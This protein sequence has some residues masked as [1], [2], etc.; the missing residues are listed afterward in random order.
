MGECNPKKVIIAG[1]RTFDDKQFL[2]DKVGWW[3]GMLKSVPTILVFSGTAAGA[4]TLGEA[5]AKYMGFHIVRWPPDWDSHG[6]KAGPVRNCQMAKNADVLLAFWDGKSKGTK[7]M[8][9]EALRRGLEV[10]VWQY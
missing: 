5:W 9:N 7:H 4:D 10:H 6:V 1:T 2:F 8:I 3:Y